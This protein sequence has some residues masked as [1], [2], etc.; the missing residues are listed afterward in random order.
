MEN[1]EK[2]LLLNWFPDSKPGQWANILK[3]VISF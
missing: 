2:N 3:P 1:V